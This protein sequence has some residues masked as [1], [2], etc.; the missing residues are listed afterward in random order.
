MAGHSPRPKG[1]MES[2]A[3][4]LSNKLGVEVKVGR[5]MEFVQFMHMDRIKHHQ[6]C[7]SGAF[8]LTVKAMNANEVKRMLAMLCDLHDRGFFKNANEPLQQ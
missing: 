3:E 6:I 4:I 7:F 1:L 5:V 8:P 2:Q